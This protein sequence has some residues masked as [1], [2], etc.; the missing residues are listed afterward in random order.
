MELIDQLDACLKFFA[1][2]ENVVKT[3]DYDEVYI[4]IVL[5]VPELKNEVNWTK[6]IAK[7]IDKLQEDK[8]IEDI[9]VWAE[10][11]NTKQPIRVVNKQITFLGLL[12]LEQK[13]YRNQLA[14][15][16]N[17]KRQATAILLLTLVLAVGVIPPF[18]WYSLDLIKNY[19]P[20]FYCFF[21]ALGG[22]I[23]GTILGIGIRQLRK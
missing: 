10:D 12:F 23:A 19:A 14:A 20:N 3:F 16:N 15:K 4:G 21:W 2:G 18:L 5:F 8:Y 6:T 22:L 11:V 9:E 7:C 17:Q 1:H 13:G